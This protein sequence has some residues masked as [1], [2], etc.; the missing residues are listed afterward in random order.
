MPFLPF[1]FALLSLFTLTV[2]ADEPPPA[3]AARAWLLIDHGTGQVL[4]AQNPGQ[5]VEPASL[6]KIMTSYLVHAALR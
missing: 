1:L 4:A 2:Q 3:L 5:K 6:T